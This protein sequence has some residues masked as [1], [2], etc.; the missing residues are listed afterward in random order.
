MTTKKKTTPSKKPSTTKKRQS[1]TVRRKADK[2]AIANKIFE[3]YKTGEFTLESCSGEH[4]I[5]ARTL[6]NWS[7]QFSE[8][9]EAYKEAKE[10][11]SKVKK[12]GLRKK[13]IDGLEK[14][15]TG[16]F[17]EEEEIR[18]IKNVSGQVIQ[19]ISTKKKKYIAPNATAII[20]ALK[21]LDPENFNKDAAT[22][23]ETEEQ[24]FK[25]GDSIIKF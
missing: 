9:S 14:L 6:K 1:S 2:I 25:I 21:A 16:F 23:E 10:S 12:E 3:L 15:V 7:D 13:S 24:V 5:T 4:G 19:T 8:I 20:F 18:Q 17:V 22:P 11:A